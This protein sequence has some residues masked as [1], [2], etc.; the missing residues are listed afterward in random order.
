MADKPKPKRKPEIIYLRVEKGMLVPAD[1]FAR[2]QLKAKGYHT[3]DV[4]AATL[5]KLN[6]PGFDRLLHRIGQLCA[7]N[8]EAFH[9]LGAHQVLKKLQIESNTHCEDLPILLP[10][11]G[12]VAT[13]RIPLSLNFEE[14]DDGLRHEIGLSWCRWIA[15]TYWT[16]LTPE[17]VEEM[18]ESFV[19]EI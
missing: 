6:N 4:L 12:I 2:N 8:I 14:V 17:Q 1:G 7:A 19:A 3:G 18:A 13:Q 16:S 9:G 10:E 11:L 15:K 5:K